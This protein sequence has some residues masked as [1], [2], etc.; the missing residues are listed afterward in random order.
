MSTVAHQKTPAQTCN[1]SNKTTPKGSSGRGW[2]RVRQKKKAREE[3]EKLVG[4]EKEGKKVND[5][6]K[7]D[8][9]FLVFLQFRFTAR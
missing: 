6:R 9:F 8:S 1:Y 4:E 2:E 5:N 7:T 3:R